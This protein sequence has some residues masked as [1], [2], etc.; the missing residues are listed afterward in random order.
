MAAKKVWRF[1]IAF[2]A[3]SWDTPYNIKET[4]WPWS[5]RWTMPVSLMHN[6]RLLKCPI[7]MICLGPFR[8]RMAAKIRRCLVQSN[9]M[10]NKAYNRLIL[11]ILH[12]KQV[13]RATTQWMQ[14]GRDELCRKSER[15]A[16]QWPL[17]QADS[18]PVKMWTRFHL[19]DKRKC[20]FSLP[21]KRM[22]RQSPR[23][24]LR[25]EF[26]VHQKPENW[27]FKM[28]KTKIMQMA[29]R[30]YCHKTG[31]RKHRTTTSRRQTMSKT[32]DNPNN[33]IKISNLHYQ[34]DCLMLFPYRKIKKRQNVKIR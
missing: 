10:L 14:G 19:M 28:Q 27:R 33:H 11:L 23:L 32:A 6:F 3:Y 16:P 21:R 30:F 7:S 2:K 17:L 26:W 20:H 13:F 9:S 15:K 31:G 24:K 22:F 8:S 12:I 25:L 4:D 1:P 5:S 18:E 29:K 34:L